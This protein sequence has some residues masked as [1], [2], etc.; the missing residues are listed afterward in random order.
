MKLGLFW[1]FDLTQM[2]VFFDSFLVVN[3]LWE[4]VKSHL[5]RASRTINITFSLK[6]LL[7]ITISGKKENGSYSFVQF[8]TVVLNLIRKIVHKYL[9]DCYLV[10]TCFIRIQQYVQIKF[11]YQAITYVTTGVFFTNPT[12][13]CSLL[14]KLIKLKHISSKNYEIS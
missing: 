9:F 8:I 1:W 3:F 2:Y 14:L 7:G 5:Q 11:W 13:V 4:N 6:I 10:L 12:L